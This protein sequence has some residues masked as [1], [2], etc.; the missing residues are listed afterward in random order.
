[1]RGVASHE[2][3]LKRVPIVGMLLGESLNSGF[4]R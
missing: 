3:P 2:M 4:V 1:M